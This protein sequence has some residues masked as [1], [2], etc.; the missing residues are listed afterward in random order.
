ML[1]EILVPSNG[2]PMMLV[3]H[4]R[5]QSDDPKV[6]SQRMRE[7]LA[8]KKHQMKAHRAVALLYSPEVDLEDLVYDNRFVGPD[9]ALDADVVRLRLAA[10][11]DM[12]Q[13]NRTG[14]IRGLP[15]NK[16]A[17]WASNRSRR[18]TK[19]R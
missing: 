11:S 12:K 10:P 6:E 8:A 5:S 16:S 15:I 7:Y 19:R 2:Q 13:A 14:Q 9:S 18:K 3:T 4:V 1:T 17:K